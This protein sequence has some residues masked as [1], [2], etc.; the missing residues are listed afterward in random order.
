MRA[1]VTPLVLCLLASCSGGP[2]EPDGV[3]Y[4]MIHVSGRVTT[5][6]GSPLRGAKVELYHRE[7]S[8]PCT[9]FGSPIDDVID[10]HVYTGP[11]GYFE[12][13][14]RAWCS[15]STGPS[16]RAIAPEFIPYS[17][18]TRCTTE[19]QVF[20]FELQPPPP[21]STLSAKRRGYGSDA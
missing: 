12:I 21:G 2:T 19:L 17:R 8:E 7:C 15:R 4:E 6:D 13:E 20:D 18:S 1:S 5:T 11:D 10:G 3:H 14:T 9:G 16:L